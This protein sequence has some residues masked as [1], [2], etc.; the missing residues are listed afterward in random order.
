MIEVYRIKISEREE[1]LKHKR[2]E[3]DEEKET[4]SFH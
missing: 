3:E 1:F 2:V 4:N